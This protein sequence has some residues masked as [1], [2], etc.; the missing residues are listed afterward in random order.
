M[1]CGKEPSRS[2]TKR[3]TIFKI[4]HLQENRP[5]STPP[6]V[7]RQKQDTERRD[8]PQPS[9]QTTIQRTNRK[10]QEWSA[11]DRALCEERKQYKK[12]A[13]TFYSAVYQARFLESCSNYNWLPRGLTIKKQLMTVQPDCSNIRADFRDTLS[14]ASRNLTILLRNHLRKVEASTQTKALEAKQRMNYLTQKCNTNELIS[15]ERF[16]SAT[17]KNIERHGTRKNREVNKMLFEIAGRPTSMPENTKV[18]KVN[19]YNRNCYRPPAHRINE[20]SKNT[21]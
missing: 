13:M 12:Q 6:L 3:F 1:N 15:H 2:T 5:G 10:N 7:Q 19:L 16:L 18:G 14:Q 11:T 17:E 8:R 20:T 21:E 9:R 4:Y